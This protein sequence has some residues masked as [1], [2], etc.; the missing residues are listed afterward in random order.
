MFPTDSTSQAT[1][2]T[3]NIT[4]LRLPL[5]FLCNYIA[6]ERRCCEARGETEEER[7]DP[8]PAR[9][10]QR[11]IPPSLQPLAGV[12]AGHRGGGHSRFAGRGTH[13]ALG[14]GRG[15]DR[16]RVTRRGWPRAHRR[17]ARRK[18]WRQGLGAERDRGGRA[19]EAGHRGRSGRSARQGGGPRADIRCDTGGGRRVGGP[20]TS[21]HECRRRAFYELCLYGV[22]GVWP[23]ST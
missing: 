1:P 9:R 5:L 12:A 11:R 8:R 14:G 23:L 21:I 18:P 2:R 17:S 20:L 3:P 10:R 22:L 16:P 19:P 6:P 13:D 4:T 15:A 7:Y